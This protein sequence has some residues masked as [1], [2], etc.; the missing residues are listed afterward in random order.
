MQYNTQRKKMKLPEYGRSIQNMVDYAITIEDKNE[1]Q[2]CANTIIAIM[3]NM[4]PQLR[5]VTDFNHKLWDHLAIMSD[6][7]LDIDYPYEI[8]PQNHLESRP[9]AIKYPNTKINFRHYGRSLELLI[10]KACEFEEGSEKNNMI[11][12]IA[13]HMKKSYTTWNKDVVEDQKIIDDIYN[14]SDGKLTITPEILQLMQKRMDDG[15]RKQTGNN[16]NNGKAKMAN[17]NK[18]NRKRFDQKR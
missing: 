14:L 17:N 1:R 13:N 4:N 16:K 11:A 12:L 2:R 3:G 7:K 15:M 8:V 18:N 5:D 6:F 9:E 10:K